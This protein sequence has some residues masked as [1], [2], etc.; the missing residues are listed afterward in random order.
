MCY[1][2]EEIKRYL[3]IL[4]NYTNPSVEKVSRKVKCWNCQRDDCLT[5]YSGIKVCENCGGLNDHVLGY[6]DNKD[7]YRLHFRKKSIYQRKYHYK[8]KVDQVCKTLQLTEDQKYDLYN[9]LMAIDK[10]ITEI[11]NKQFCRK[12]MISIFY[13]IKKILEEMGNEKYKLVHLKISE[14]TLAYYEKWWHSYK[15]LNNPFV[16]T[17]VNNSS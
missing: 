10:N 1:S 2:E 3:E 4:H 12:R 5:I 8:K 14:Q 15:S 9:K 11:L 7:Y 13:V 6:F 16:K 17:P